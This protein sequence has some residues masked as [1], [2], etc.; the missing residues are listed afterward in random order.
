MV[1]RRQCKALQYTARGHSVLENRITKLIS[2]KAS[3][4]TLCLSL[5]AEGTP[6]TLTLHS[7]DLNHEGSFDEAVQGCAYVCHVASPVIMKVLYTRPFPFLIHA[8][9]TPQHDS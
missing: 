8:L 9:T 1:A 6:G 5:Q 4:V 7:A 2:Q 3:W